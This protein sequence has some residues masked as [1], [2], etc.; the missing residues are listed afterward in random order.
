MFKKV[1]CNYAIKLDKDIE[2]IATVQ[3]GDRFRVNTINAYGDDFSN[4]AELM[5]LIN[6][7]YGNKHHHPLTGPI[8]VVG[9]EVG[10]VLKVTINS[11]DIRIMGQAL[12]KSAGI[13]PI[14]VEMFGDRAPVISTHKNESKYIDYM[15]GIRVKYRP[16]LGMI[17]NAPSEGFIKTGHAGITGGN[18]DIPF[19]T[20]GVSVYIPVQVDGAKLFL[21]DAHGSQGYG[22]L[23]GVALEAS[24]STIITVDV[25]K[26]RKEF[27]GIV[28]V[29][30][31]PVAGRNAI[32]VIGVADKMG[33]VQSSIL[34]AYKNS[35]SM[36]SQIF[37]TYNQ[38]IVCN[39]ISA[40]GHSMMGQAFSKT[41][42]STSIIN[43]Y[44]D[45]I[46]LAKGVNVYDVCKEFDSI[47]FKA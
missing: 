39:M 38:N 19:V 37:T 44:S 43:I 16:M 7:K 6:G 35:V 22:E 12:S 10:D 47:F 32:G 14:H 36:L 4:M 34:D 26:P 9:A 8:D 42:E 23:G 17:G 46:A 5:G 28:L 21:G 2:T 3:S 30:K 1:D 20:E 15:S 11:I 13:D 27:N 31:E 40:F 29:G 18:L 45:D 33:D 25:L 41:S 24:A